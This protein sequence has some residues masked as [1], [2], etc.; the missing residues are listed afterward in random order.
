MGNRRIAALLT[1][2]ALAG[3]LLVGVPATAHAAT[4]LT[5]SQ[6]VEQLG[7]VGGATLSATADGFTETISGTPGDGFTV[8]FDP[9]PHM[10]LTTSTTS[11]GAT[12]RQLSTP[13]AEY[14][15]LPRDATTI[16]AITLAGKPSATWSY[17]LR[18]SN[19]LYN[20]YLVVSF[21]LDGLVAGEPA[22]G[23]PTNVVDTA[24]LTTDPDG[25]RH[26]DITTHDSS[27]SPV[28]LRAFTVTADT[29]DRLTRMSI[30]EGPTGDS[31][32][33]STTESVVYGRPMLTMPTAVQVISTTS[34]FLAYDSLR[35]RNRVGRVVLDTAAG[36][37][38]YAAA[39]HRAV[40]ARD[41]RGFAKRSV[42]MANRATT[43]IRWYSISTGAVVY[44]RNPF[45]HELVTYRVSV[46]HG[47]AVV[48]RLS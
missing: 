7:T 42:Q 32:R 34:L 13:S 38:S 40:I 48:T 19:Q 35:L 25:T 6:A 18:P 15:T 8:Q 14:Q 1:G 29:Q 33:W 22:P 3:S 44:A 26:W 12:L 24:S 11:G 45:T 9:V 2:T 5:P 20:N 37:N 47:K 10:R 21:L 28:Y 23:Q 31:A 17:Y 4:T 46:R 43:L 30:V 27:T 41:I 36:A 39:R 16:A